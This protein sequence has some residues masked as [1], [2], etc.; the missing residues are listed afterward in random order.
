MKNVF[1][2]H[3]AVVAIFCKNHINN[4]AFTAETEEEE[5]V[6][7]RSRK[8][9]LL[10]II[11]DKTFD[12]MKALIFG[13]EEARPVLKKSSSEEEEE[14]TEE[15]ESEEE[16]TVVAVAMTRRTT[17]VR[18]DPVLMKRITA[19]IAFDRSISQKE[20]QVDES[21]SGYHQ[22]TA[23]AMQR[24]KTRVSLRRATA[25]QKEAEELAAKSA[26]SVE[27]ENEEEE[28]SLNQTLKSEELATVMSAMRDVTEDDESEEATEENEDAK[29]DLSDR[30]QQ[31]IAEG[32]ENLGGIAR[33][34]APMNK[35]QLE[36]AD[37]EE[38]EGEASDEGLAS[39]E[40]GDEEE[41]EE[42]EEG[43]KIQPLYELVKGDDL[44]ESDRWDNFSLK[45]LKMNDDDDDDDE[46]E[47]EDE[48]ED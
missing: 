24:H 48:D 3:A 16:E 26:M 46:D 14:E 34:M 20:I 11:K 9:I 17:T 23:A 25:L 7:E 10:H 31:Y 37:E 13:G 42:E 27:E 18:Q 32:S 40:G 36:G 41:E 39:E 43:M 47:D 44:S 21:K 22:A 6:E 8:D 2:Y 28:V 1:Y 30:I 33:E 4:Y 35:V 12:D 29:P 5:E 45:S 38:E 19:D 15:E